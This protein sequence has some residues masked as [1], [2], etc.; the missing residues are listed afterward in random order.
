MD[1]VYEGLF[2]LDN[3]FPVTYHIWRQLVRFLVEAIGLDPKYY[4]PH[5]F[6]IGQATDMSM[7]GE[8][9]ERIMKFIGWK[10]RKSAMTYIRPDNEDFVKFQ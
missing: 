9:I 1:H 2:L 6:R 7:N 8:P 4:P 10:N 3:G 5:S